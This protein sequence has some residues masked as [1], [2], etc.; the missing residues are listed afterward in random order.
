MFG[1]TLVNQRKKRELKN[2]KNSIQRSL[3]MEGV[4]V[5]SNNKNSSTEKSIISEIRK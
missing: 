4:K 2:E 1:I 3:G 5:K